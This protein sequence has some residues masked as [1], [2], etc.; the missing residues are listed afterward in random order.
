MAGEN[1]ISHSSAWQIEPSP[2]HSIIIRLVTGEGPDQILQAPGPRAF[3]GRS[4]MNDITIHDPAVSRTH[5]K[6]RLVDN[7]WFVQDMWSRNGTM[8]RGKQIEPGLEVAV[9]EGDRI[10]VG[11]FTLYLERSIATRSADDEGN[12]TEEILKG[13][14]DTLTLLKAACRDRPMTYVKNMELLHVMS[15]ALMETV[16]LQAIFQKMM[17]YMFELFKRIDRAAILRVVPETREIEEV[18][19]RTREGVS[20][21]EGRPY[22]RTIV[23]AVLDSGTSFIMPDF[24]EMD[25][26]DRSDS[27]AFIRSVLCVPLISRS[28]VRGMIYVDSIGASHSFREEDRILLDALSSQAAVA[29]ENATLLANL[30]QTVER[31]THALRKTELQLRESEIR[32]KA[33]FRTMN[34]GAMVLDAVENGRDFRI[35]DLNKAALQ[36]EG[37]PREEV[38]NKLLTEALPFAVSSGLMSELRN[39]W[40]SGRP[41]ALSVSFPTHKPFPSHRDYYLYRL[42]SHEVVALYDDVTDKM[43]AEKEQRELHLQL[44]NA[45]KMESIG[46]IAAGV[47]HNFRNILQAVYGNVEYIEMLYGDKPEIA[48]ITRSVY[49]SVRRGSDLAKDLLQFSKRA[50]D[51]EDA[52]TE[53]DLTEVI[54]SALAILSRSIDQK[55]TIEVDLKPD[56]FVRGRSSLLSQVFMNLFTNARDAMPHG[57]TLRVEARKEGPRILVRVSDTGTGMSPETL[58]KIFDPFFTLKD[59]GKGTGL[60]LSTSQGIIEQHGGRIA[61]RSKL[62]KGSAFWIILPASGKA[63]RVVEDR[64]TIQ[65]LQSSPREERVLIVDDDPVVLDAL[66]NL[67][68]S[69]GFPVRKLDSAEEALQVYKEWQPE[70]VLMDRNMPGMDGPSCIHK[71]VEQDPNARIVIISAYSDAGEDA[72]DDETRRMIRGY[73]TKPFELN[74]LVEIFSRVLDA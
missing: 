9:H 44:V 57:G 49:E 5:L 48:E 12:T 1:S 46:L 21:M 43:L 53:M 8:V 47:A 28:V 32:F 4:P 24:N 23:N 69:L 2:P 36:I 39:V 51:T 41:K 26:E 17:D 40:E 31:K 15:K 64:P 22:S 62:G 19:V 14:P 67:V 68:L 72:I 11:G 33:I 27:Q 70:L 25:D 55:I 54:Q 7:G 59:V 13:R 56:L 20:A 42:P 29:M 50:E 71:L 73:L 60:G 3:L 34:S 16:S 6:I 63:K 66:S 52:F 74:Q 65:P 38:S 45:Q 18:I 35:V 58:E 30:E 37:M 10:K 61:V